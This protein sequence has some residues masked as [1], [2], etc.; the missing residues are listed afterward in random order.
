MSLEA[1]R[2][3][4]PQPRREP[5]G[6]VGRLPAWAYQA[7]IRTLDV[8]VAGVV[9]SAALPFMVLI[10]CLVRLDSPGPALFRHGR[11]GIDRRRRSDGWQGPERRR[12]RRSGK[13][14]HLWKFRTMYADS[15]SRFPERYVYR[16]SDEELHTLPI[17]V[18]VSTHRD[19]A[20]LD[21]PVQ[22]SDAGP[23]DPR[24]T[25]VGR[26]LRRA[27]LDELP[28]L[29][30]V[31]AGDL[32]LV[33]PRPDMEANVPYYSEGQMRKF[34]VKPGVTGLAQVR[35][36]GLLSF[37]EIN[38]YDLRYIENRCLTLDLRILVETVWVLV[39]GEGAY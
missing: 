14:F 21:G 15:R 31:L 16:Y 8:V 10:A 7:I 19:P 29:I 6:R 18:L 27:S 2:T 23:R 39:R 12:T 13:P 34:E 17:K 28:N 22:S 24:L 25:R 37:R 9:L 32:H 36:R 20:K 33:G 30:N 38:E 1:I 4:P 5:P 11:V 26:W 3:A 35:G